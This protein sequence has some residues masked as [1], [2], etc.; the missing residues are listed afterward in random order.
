MTATDILT[1]VLPTF[2][3]IFI[4]YAAGRLGLL[5]EPVGDALGSYVFTIA[6]P[7]LLIRTIAKAEFPDVSPWPLW[8]T[9]FAG[10]LV[11]WLSGEFIIRRLFRRDV[12]SAVIGGLSAAYSNLVL[13][14]IPIVYTVYGEAGLVPLMLLIAVHL[15]LMAIATAARFEGIEARERGGATDWPR[16]VASTLRH[17]LKNPL[18]IGIFAG[19]AVKLTGLPMTGVPGAIVD[20]ISAT[21]VP[22]ALFTLGL[23]L[24]RYGIRENFA[25]GL[26]L[27]A[28]KL[29]LLPGIVYLVATRLSGMPALWVAVLTVCAASPTGV[30]PYLFATRHGAGHAI[31]A[32]TMTIGSILGVATMIFWMLLVGAG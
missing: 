16:L 32:N 10:A 28:V 2:G 27:T 5:A 11:A 25:A 30:N 1:L 15:P 20:Q 17:M 3:I 24:K 9:Y 12:R 29:L 26:V 7:L 21:G 19:L 4:G 14:G 8:L 13:L 22:C 18:I 31:A 23:G 6:L